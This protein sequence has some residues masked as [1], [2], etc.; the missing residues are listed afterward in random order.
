MKKVVIRNY[1]EAIAFFVKSKRTI[2]AYSK[3]AKF[4]FIDGKMVTFP[5]S[6]TKE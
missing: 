5:F 3:N 1:K 6:V 2:G 4:I